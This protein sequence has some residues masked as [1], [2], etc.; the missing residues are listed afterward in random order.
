MVNLIKNVD[1]MALLLLV[2]EKFEAWMN[3]ALQKFAIY[4]RSLNFVMFFRL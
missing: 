1:F 2:N 3:A 4:L